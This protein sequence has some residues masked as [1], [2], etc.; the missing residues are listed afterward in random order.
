MS[1]AF[2]TTAF[3]RGLDP[4]LRFLTPDQVRALVDYRGDATLVHRIEELAAKQNEGDLTSEEIAEYQGY[5]QAN[6]FIAILQAR[7]KALLQ[8]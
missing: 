4:V 6:R 3:E 7:A 1:T 5:V 8:T 2:A